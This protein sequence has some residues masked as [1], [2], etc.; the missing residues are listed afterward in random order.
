MGVPFGVLL[1]VLAMVLEFIPMIGPLTAV[2]IILLVTVI[3][4][5]H[6]WIVV[7]LHRGLPHVPGLLPL[8][9]T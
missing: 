7:D 9:R 4:G 8:R 2:A 5:A 6:F 1:A 3:A